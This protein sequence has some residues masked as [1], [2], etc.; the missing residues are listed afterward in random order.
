MEG[1]H[2]Q[3]R[4][5]NVPPWRPAAFLGGRGSSIRK[6][7]LNRDLLAVL[8]AGLLLVFGLQIAIR[9]LRD[10]PTLYRLEAQS[11]RNAARQVQQSLLTRVETLEMLTL[12]YGLWDETYEFLD[13]TP[14]SEEW[15]EYLESNLD[16]PYDTFLIYDINGFIFLDSDH[17]LVYSYT[18]DLETG[19]LGRELDLE[20]STVREALTVRNRPPSKVTR[21]LDPALVNSGFLLSDQG[22]VLFAASE[23][24]KTDFGVVRSVIERSES[25]WKRT[26]K[27]DTR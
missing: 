10:L 8:F 25:K 19:K 15:N 16:Y 13:S 27:L 4:V 2:H 11:D 14:G 20:S 17:S 22:P 5:R 7:T 26:R 9:V 3:G 18:L 12:D 24:Y 1:H 21:A 6:A 23:V